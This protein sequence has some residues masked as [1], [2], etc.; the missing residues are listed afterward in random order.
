MAFFVTAGKDIFPLTINRSRYSPND[1]CFDQQGTSADCPTW[2][3]FGKGDGHPSRLNLNE[4]GIRAK[5]PSSNNYFALFF[6]P[7]YNGYQGYIDFKNSNEERTIIDSSLLKMTNTK[8]LSFEYDG[9]YEFLKLYRRSSTSNYSLFY[10]RGNFEIS[11]DDSQSRTLLKINPYDSSFYAYNYDSSGSNYSIVDASYPQISAGYNVSYFGANLNPNSAIALI[12]SS[13]SSYFGFK[14]YSYLTYYEFGVNPSSDSILWSI[15]HNN[16]QYFAIYVD[17]EESSYWTYDR[18]G[19]NL[20]WNS[21]GSGVFQIWNDYNYCHFLISCRPTN[22]ESALWSRDADGIN[23]L[24]N[25]NKNGI[26]QMWKDGDWPYIGLYGR[27]QASF[28]FSDGSFTDLKFNSRQGMLQIWN[29]TRNTYIDL[30]VYMLE[31]GHSATF[32]YVY[33]NGYI[34]KGADGRYI[35]ILST[36]PIDVCDPKR[37]GA[38]YGAST[39]SNRDPNSDCVLSYN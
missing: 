8:A 33:C 21:R 5:S 18:Q 32:N 36:H 35:K 20:L 29:S 19:T 39:S 38:S 26:L 15:G 24:W 11:A 13:G 34:L 12:G 23:L 4:F 25:S 17:R 7:R 2:Y 10:D 1:R 14:L 28:W 30:S 37:I 3:N 9:I 31:S 16:G 27:N 6:G 22:R